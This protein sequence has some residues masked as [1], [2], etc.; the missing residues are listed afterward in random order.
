[1]IFQ[2]LKGL[3][4]EPGT[5]AGA[6]RHFVDKFEKLRCDQTQLEDALTSFGGQWDWL[7]ATEPSAAVNSVQPAPIMVT[8]P[9]SGVSTPQMLTTQQPLIHSPSA[10]LTSPKLKS[11]KKIKL[12]EKEVAALTNTPQSVFSTNIV[13]EHQSFKVC[14]KYLIFF[15][16]TTCPPATD[17]S[18]A[19]RDLHSNS[20]R[21]RVKEEEESEMWKLQRLP[22]QR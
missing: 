20:C 13:G 10:D 22:Q 16:W 17:S 21:F 7:V 5:G 11:K 12:D 18:G 4:K 8:A 6:V 15:R 19:I 1:M 9:L 14:R 2:V 3:L